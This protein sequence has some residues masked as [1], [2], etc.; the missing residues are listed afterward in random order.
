MSTM[1]LSETRG[2]WLCWVIRGGIGLTRRLGAHW[3]RAYRRYGS[4]PSNPSISRTNGHH[5]KNHPRWKGS[6]PKCSSGLQFKFLCV[7]VFS[8]FPKCQRNGCDLACQREPCHGWLDAFVQ[9]GLIEILQWA[10]PCTRGD[11]GR[12]EQTF[13]IVVMVFIQAA[14]GEQF[15]G[16]PQLAFDIAVFR[17]DP[18]LQRQSAVGPQ[19]PLG[20]NR[21]GVWIS[22]TSSAERIGP[23]QGI[24]RS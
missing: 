18:G 13:Q 7:E 22:A 23:I 10:G 19:L 11:S 8:F 20:A 5:R 21:W 2:L 1:V 9:G 6:H 3:A 4:S 12:F 14:N 16:A 17:A 15:L 24:C